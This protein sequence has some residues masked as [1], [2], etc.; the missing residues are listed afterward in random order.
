MGRIDGK[1]VT[2]NCDREPGRGKKVAEPSRLCLFGLQQRR[3]CGETPQPGVWPFSA[4][5]GPRFF[6]KPYGFP[7]CH[8]VQ[9]NGSIPIPEGCQL[10]AGGRGAPRRHPRTAGGTNSTPAGVAAASPC[11]DFGV[12]HVRVGIL[13][14]VLRPSRFCYGWVFRDL[15]HPCRGAILHRRV[16]GGIASL[17]PRLMAG[18]PPGFPGDWTFFL[19]SV[20]AI[21]QV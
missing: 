6:R 18:N 3:F 16:S 21:G 15:W 14:L 19:N 5:V 20:D 8:R 4:A 1:Q 9:P 11:A 12:S 10:L 17:N 13:Y 7:P 2:T